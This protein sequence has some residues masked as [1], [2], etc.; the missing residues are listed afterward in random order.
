[1]VNNLISITPLNLDMTAY[2]FI[3]DLKRWKLEEL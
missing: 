3:D 1:L 2:R